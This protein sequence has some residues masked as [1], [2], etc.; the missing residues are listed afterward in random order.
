MADIEKIVLPSGDEYNIKDS[1][2]RQMTLLA[3][4]TSATQDLELLFDSPSN[5]DNTEY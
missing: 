5:V 3:I 1:A 4:Y 2:A